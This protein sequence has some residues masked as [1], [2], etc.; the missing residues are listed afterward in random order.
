MLY[1]ATREDWLG[2]L[3]TWALLRE[4]AS[5]KIKRFCHKVSHL[6]LVGGRV[7]EYS[8]EVDGIHKDWSTYAATSIVK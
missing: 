3:L 6:V 5:K 1:M 2:L 4:I 7:K 8:A